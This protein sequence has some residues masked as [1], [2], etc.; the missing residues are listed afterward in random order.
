MKRLAAFV[1]LLTFG[2]AFSMPVYA[3]R[4]T[5]EENA[6]RS[7]KAAKKQEK[8]LRKANKRQRKAARRSEKAQRKQM[9]KANRQLQRRS[10]STTR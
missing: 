5:P 2:L 4:I 7:S 8:M 3:Q 6:R 10:G 9:I 1:L